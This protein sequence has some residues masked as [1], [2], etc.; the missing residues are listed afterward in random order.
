MDNVHDIVLRDEDGNTYPTR[1]QF[2]QQYPYPNGGL[3]LVNEVGG[4]SIFDMG[5]WLRVEYGE[6][7]P[8]DNTQ[9]FDIDGTHIPASSMTIDPTSG[10]IIL[11]TMVVE[12]SDSGDT[13]NSA[14]P[15]VA[16]MKAQLILAGTEWEVVKNR[17]N[18]SS[19]I[20]ATAKSKAVEMATNQIDAQLL[21]KSA[22]LPRDKRQSMIDEL[23]QSLV[24]TV[25]Q[26]D[27]PQYDY[28]VDKGL[29]TETIHRVS[30]VQFDPRY[31]GILMQQISFDAKARAYRSTL[32]MLR[33]Y[34]TLEMDTGNPYDAPKKFVID[35]GEEIWGTEMH[36]EPTN[37]TTSVIGYIGTPVEGQ[38]EADGS[39]K[40]QK[41]I[42]KQY[43]RRG[44]FQYVTITGYDA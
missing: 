35:G 3:A 40:V 2:S 22:N 38:F 20:L 23:S 24:D 32:Y 44:A 10:T 4:M 27:I 33:D 17:T 9:I 26:N 34:T 18:L 12:S 7:E 21:E 15:P 29:P 19:D 8:D 16:V 31:Q 5:Q 28:V 30:N 1:I 6:F 13:M 14:K 37:S 36:Y 11:Q 25:I 43:L 39:P 42:Q 41:N